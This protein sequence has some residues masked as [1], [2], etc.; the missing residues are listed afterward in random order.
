MFENSVNIA[1]NAQRSFTAT[2]GGQSDELLTTGVYDVWAESDVYIK[3]DEDDASD[4]TASTG[5]L[6]LVDNIIPVRITTP[7]YL[8]AIGTGDVFFHKVGE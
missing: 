3:T 1:G 4:V 5:Y 2:G 6:I 7:S 8:G